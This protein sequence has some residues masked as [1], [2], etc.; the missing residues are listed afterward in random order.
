[1]SGTVPEN[2]LLDA[3]FPLQR[4][5][6]PAHDPPLRTSCQQRR[7]IPMKAIVAQPNGESL[8]P[9]MNYAVW[10]GRD[11]LG[12]LPSE[13]LN[14]VRRGASLAG[15]DE[16]YIGRLVEKYEERLMSWWRRE[17]QST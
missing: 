14:V 11:V 13:Y 3:W 16:D 6:P 1:M 17:S 2:V 12:E 5:G 8:P 7:V 9:G 15:V 10:N 4:G